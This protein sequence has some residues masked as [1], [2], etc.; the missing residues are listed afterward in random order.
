MVGKAAGKTEP[1][2]LGPV[3]AVVGTYRDGWEG[4]GGAARCAARCCYALDCTSCCVAWRAGRQRCRL[5]HT[6]GCTTHRTALE[7]CPTHMKLATV[8]TCPLGS[9]MGVLWSPS[10][11]CDS[12]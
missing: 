5:K 12:P 6:C 10:W 4:R 11:D 9:T 2:Q 8:V 3:A 7:A 1:D